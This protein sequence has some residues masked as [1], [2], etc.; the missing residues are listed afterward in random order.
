MVGLSEAANGGVV[1]EIYSLKF[2]NIHREHL[3]WSPFVKHLKTFRPANLL[4]ET[5]TQV[6]PCQYCKI[7]ITTYFENHLQTAAF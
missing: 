6:I 7:Y 4:K 2:C 1:E 3:C 5:L